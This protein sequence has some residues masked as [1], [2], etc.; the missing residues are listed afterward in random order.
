M[1]KLFV[2]AA[3][4]CCIQTIHWTSIGQAHAHSTYRAG[5]QLEMLNIC[6]YSVQYLKCIVS[7]FMRFQTGPKKL[8]VFVFVNYP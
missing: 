2:V 6:N 7:F 1:F 3:A 4:L 8:L 5:E